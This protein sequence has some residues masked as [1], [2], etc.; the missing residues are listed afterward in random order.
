MYERLLVERRGPVGWLIFDRPDVGNAMDALMMTEL[1]QAWRELDADP[2]VRVIVN[3][4]QGKNFQTGLDVA[5]LSR[6]KAAMTEQSRRTRDAELRF[7]GWHNEVWKPVIAAVNGNCVGGGLHFV[8]DADIVLAAS[9][10]RFFDTHVSVG[11]VMAYEGVGLVR[12]MAFEPIMRLALTGRYER[13]SA[14]RAHQLGMVSQVVDPP[15]RLRDEAQ[16][17]AEKIAKNSPAAMRATKRALWGALERGLTDA[18]RNGS[19]EMLSMWGHPDQEEGPLAFS[20]KRDAQWM[21][22][23]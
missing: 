21:E 1:E 3:T 5:A 7:T 8:A 9:D 15:E 10:A 20:E 17:L 19:Q 22:L 4:G 2:A 16:A 23:S 13:V 18:C 11:Q 14:A 6:D 12:K